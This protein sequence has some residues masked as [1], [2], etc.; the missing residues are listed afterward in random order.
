[1]TNV[2]SVV[3]VRYNTVIIP[4]RSWSQKRANM[5]VST[6]YR[7]PNGRSN[8]TRYMSKLLAGVLML[9]F[10]VRLIHIAHVDP[11]LIQSCLS[12]VNGVPNVSQFV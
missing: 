7:L 5:T 2:G 9:S 1:M 6:Q 12:I 11:T 10:T 3:T 4:A 8:V